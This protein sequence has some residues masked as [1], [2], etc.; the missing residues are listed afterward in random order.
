MLREKREH[1]ATSSGYEAAQAALA[2]HLVQIVNRLE[3]EC[4]GLYTPIRSEFNAVVA[5]AADADCNALAWSLPYCRREPR[6]MEF[7][8]W[9]RRAPSLLDECGIAS[10]G[11]ALVVPDVLLVPCVGYTVANHRLGYGG[12]Y[13]DRYLA[14]HPHVT[15]VGVAWSFSALSEA[16]YAAQPH[17]LPLTLI[18]TEQ[19]V[20]G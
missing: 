13:F 4:L 8:R 1:F 18:V 3:P 11:G 6:E 12:G 14:A 15:T 2:H 19:G 20:A 7:R 9:D 16:D 10:T 5:L 17:D